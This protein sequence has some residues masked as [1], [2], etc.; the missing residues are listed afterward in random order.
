MSVSEVQK[1]SVSPP[2]FDI[3]N[4][5]GAVDFESQYELSVNEPME[6]T[7]IYQHHP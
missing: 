6:H 4:V 5:S 3:Q 1:I 7:T 2:E